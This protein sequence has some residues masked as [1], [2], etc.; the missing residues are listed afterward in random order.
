MCSEFYSSER[1]LLRTQELGTLGTQLS[2]NVY[3][4]SSWQLGVTKPPHSVFSLHGDFL[5]ALVTH[6]LSH[7][8][9]WPAMDLSLA[10]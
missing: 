7:I 1:M 8:H 6:W 5:E 10:K 3:Q 4:P 2:L 9:D